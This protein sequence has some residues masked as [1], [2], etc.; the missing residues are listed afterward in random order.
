MAN[1]SE[2][3]GFY[4]VEFAT[5]SESDNGEKEDCR[6]KNLALMT[7]LKMLVS[8]RIG[9]VVIPVKKLLQLSTGAV[10]GLNSQAG[11]PVDLYVNGMPIAEGDVIIINDKYGIRITNVL[12]AEERQKRLQN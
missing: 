12:N 11:S 7:N 10:V 9:S 1:V 2:Y 8:V 5:I 4:E 3:N 6:K